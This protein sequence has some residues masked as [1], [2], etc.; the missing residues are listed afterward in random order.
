MTFHSVRSKHPH[1]TISLR[2]RDLYKKDHSKGTYR[3]QLST[4]FLVL[5]N[6]F[7]L[8]YCITNN[9][10]CWAP[11][12][13]RKWGPRRHAR[14]IIM[15][16]FDYAPK[17]REFDLILVRWYAPQ[18]SNSIGNTKETIHRPIIRSGWTAAAS[19]PDNNS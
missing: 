7:D 10:N 9:R 13:F 17:C 18:I 1:C 11:L 2:S 3:G 19:P 5:W 16:A 4:F 8:Y 14:I 15:L 12:H 6:T